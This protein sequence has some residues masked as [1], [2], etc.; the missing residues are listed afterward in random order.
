MGGSSI[1]LRTLDLDLARP[2]TFELWTSSS[3]ASCLLLDH[4]W[5]DAALSLS[6]RV[7]ASHDGKDASTILAVQADKVKKAIDEIE[8][9][10]NVVKT[11]VVE[12]LERK[13]VQRGSNSSPRL[14]W[15]LSCLF[16]SPSAHAHDV[17][18]R[19]IGSLS[20]A[21]RHPHPYLSIRITTIGSP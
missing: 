16:T 8:E 13:C 15:L 7:G 11:A 10:R 2:S 4:S 19:S 21:R 18:P 9:R 12:D 5:E 3:L 17:D 14:S 6:S 20:K 1:D